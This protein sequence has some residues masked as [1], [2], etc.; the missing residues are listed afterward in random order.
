M[1]KYTGKGCLAVD[2]PGFSETK[3]K[4]L[5]SPPQVRRIKEAMIEDF[6][7]PD[8]ILQMEEVLEALNEGVLI[9][10]ANRIVFVNSGYV[11][12]TGMRPEDL[13]GY[14]IQLF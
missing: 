12:M 1:D 10:Q 5:S 7:R 4:N 3:L 11:R 2:G 14:D 13:V 6:E 8:W 9:A